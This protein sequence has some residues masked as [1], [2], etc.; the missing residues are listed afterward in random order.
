MLWPLEATK[1]KETESPLWLES[2]LWPREG[3]QPHCFGHHHTS[4]HRTAREQ[5][6]VVFTHYMLAA[7]CYS[8]RELEHQRAE[9]VLT[10]ISANF[11]DCC[12][13]LN[14]TCLRTASTEALE[15]WS[16][17]VWPAAP[18]TWPR[19]WHSDCRAAWL[20]LASVCAGSPPR[21]GLYHPQLLLTFQGLA[22]GNFPMSPGSPTRPPGSLSK[23]VYVSF[24]FPANR[25]LPP[26]QKP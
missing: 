20:L 17:S 3:T 6:C 24:S 2:P 15:I 14:P 1:G 7:I 13:S 8:N 18:L 10:P 16:L 11:P 5:L 12:Q 25:P 9:N 26:L 4:T 19:F 22:P 21:K 23:I